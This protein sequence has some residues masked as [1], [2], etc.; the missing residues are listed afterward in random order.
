ML[1]W[2][3]MV[4]KASAFS[5][6]GSLITSSV[7]KQ[8]GINQ[9]DMNDVICSYPT[10][11]YWSMKKMRKSSWFWE[12]KAVTSVCAL[13]VSK[14]LTL[15]E[16]VSAQRSSNSF[17]LSWWLFFSPAN[18]FLVCN[19]HTASVWFCSLLVGEM[20]RA[21]NRRTIFWSWWTVISKSL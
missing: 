16:Q 4:G 6:R 8:Q 18:D 7:L 17:P 15:A 2:C 10:Q 13:G 21:S 12:R 5:L 3:F 11:S 1:S 14:K 19:L 20:L 9:T